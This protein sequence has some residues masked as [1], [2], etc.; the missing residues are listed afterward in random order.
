MHQIKVDFRVIG[1]EKT[2][3]D[4]TQEIGMQP[5]KFYIKG[6]DM[7]NNSGRK[8]KQNIW[9]IEA[10]PEEDSANDL[11]IY[12]QD[13]IKKIKPHLEGFSKVCEKYYSEFACS[14][15]LE[16]DSEESIPSVHLDKEFV[17]ILSKLNS[18]LDIDIYTI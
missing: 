14:L 5:S 3:E 6:G 16:K 1:F 15:Y 9:I 4:V 17:E 7:S 8:Y 10:A 12:L 13:I 18:E 11:D 2:I